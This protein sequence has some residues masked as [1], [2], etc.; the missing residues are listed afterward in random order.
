MPR[1]TLGEDEGSARVVLVLEV[2]SALG[3]PSIALVS[4]DCA[5]GR[6]ETAVLEATVAFF[7]PPPPVRRLAFD[8]FPILLYGLLLCLV[9]LLCRLPHFG[10]FPKPQNS[11]EPPY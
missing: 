11:N 4:T 9:A 10:A 6:V 2:T 5:F 3:F 7:L 1:R 8:F